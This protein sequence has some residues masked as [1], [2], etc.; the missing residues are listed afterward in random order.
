M[1]EERG[2]PPVYDAIG[3]G[4]ARHRRPD[5]RLAAA[6]RDALGDAQTVVNVGAGTGSYEPEDRQVVA[7]EPS[8]EMIAQRPPGA[9]RVVQAGAERLPFAAQS[10][11]A[12]LA[13]LTVHHWSDWRAGLDELRRVSR[14]IIVLVTWDPTHPGF[15]LT[16]DYFPDALELDRRIFPSLPALASTLGACETRD[17]PV[18]HDCTDGFFGAY[19]RRP[20]AYLD[21]D[22][23]ASISTFSR[24]SDVE[25]RVERLRH[26]LDSGQWAS[27][28]EGLL[29]LAQLDVGFR[30]VVAHAS[31][32]A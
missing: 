20:H 28:H 10:F 16:D 24:L 29:D 18:P 31:G 25:P 11:D 7:V 19:W 27:R 5:P 15:W 13:V 23:R 9:A 26:D 12:A 17:F 21:A 2:M 3:R 4:Y 32:D 1:A 22:V 14:R 6:I 30:I 8:A